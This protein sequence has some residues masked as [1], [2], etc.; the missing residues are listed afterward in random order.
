MLLA[1]RSIPY[2]VASLPDPAR[3]REQVRR[4]PAGTLILPGDAAAYLNDFD[5][6]LFLVP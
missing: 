2:T 1:G 4:S 6:T 5:R 3:L